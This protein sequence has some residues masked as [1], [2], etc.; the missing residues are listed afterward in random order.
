[1]S[2]AT[3]SPAYKPD[4][5]A[6]YKAGRD[7]IAYRIRGLYKADRDGDVDAFV[8]KGQYT[9]YLKFMDTMVR[10]AT[11]YAISHQ[12][13]AEDFEDHLL[14]DT[15]DVCGDIH[16][17]FHNEYA[18]DNP[19]PFVIWVHQSDALDRIIAKKFPYIDRTQLERATG[20]YLKLPF[21]CS[22][23]DRLLVDALIALE[24]FGFSEEMLGDPISPSLARL[25]PDARRSPLKQRHVI[26]GFIKVNFS[27]LLLFG[28]LAAGV[29]Y[30]GTAGWMGS[31]WSLGIG[32]VLVGLYLLSTVL[33]LIALPFAWRQQ[34]KARN[35]VTSTIREMVC[36]YQEMKSDGPISAS[37]IYNVVTAAAAKEIVWPGPLYALL[38]DVKAR[39]ATL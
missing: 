28:G 33:G 36:V 19:S 35:Q 18:K 4:R 7:T 3:E 31:G 39:N 8:K 24:T 16:A 11:A 1:V 23:A 25:L 20:S 38:D 5:A 15:M 27:N 6:M 29:F 2:D 22:L 10:E 32:L 37:R 13:S 17:A 12:Q 14:Y 30:A 21:R 34:T 26:V 9:Q